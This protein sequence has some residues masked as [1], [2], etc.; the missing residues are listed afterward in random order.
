MPHQK[1]Y[2]MLDDDT[3]LV[4]PSLLL[5][6]GHIDPAVPHYIGNAIGDYKGRFAHGGSAV[7]LSQA[8]MHLLFS[9][10]PDVVSA[11]HLESLTAR[12]G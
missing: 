10:N 5:V 7:V 9:Q 12:W 2:I 8:A 4:D 6:L 1:W 11:A 3:Y